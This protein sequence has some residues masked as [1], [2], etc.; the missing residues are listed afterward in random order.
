MSGSVFRP[1]NPAPGALSYELY[2]SL[3]GI[4]G[5]FA[6]LASVS[7]VTFL[8][9]GLTNGTRYYYRLRTVGAY[10]V[11]AWSLKVSARPLPPPP[12]APPGNVTATAG[13]A[14]VTLTWNAVEGATGYR[15]VRGAAGSL[16]SKVIKTTALTYKDSRLEIGRAHV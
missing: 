3:T 16:E 8:D 1:W 13:N 2:R 12:S 14:R 9:T 6:A 7:D 4:E 11:S 10:G 5:S 15:I